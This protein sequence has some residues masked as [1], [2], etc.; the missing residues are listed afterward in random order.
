[1]ESSKLKNI[2]LLILLITN[3]LLLFLMVSQRLESR[4]LQDKTLTDAV[5]LLEEK[6][7][8]V[9]AEDLSHISFPEAMTAER[10]TA[11]EQRQFTALLGEGTTL[12]QKGLVAQYDGPWGQAEVRGDGAFSVLLNPNAYPAAEG[13]EAACAKNALKLIGFTA[14]G[15]ESDGATLT[16]YQTAA[17][18]TVYSCSVTAEFGGGSLLRLSGQR[19]VGDADQATGA[20]AKSVATLL[21]RFRRYLVESGDACTAILSATVGYTTVTD[22]TGQTE[23]VPILRLKTDTNLYD[24]NALTGSIQRV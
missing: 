8:S 18:C 23:L 6:G 12:T 15:F 20:A 21:V 13:E 1:M 11:E 22:R 16:A 3:L 19:L 5:Q 17:G 2:V 4:Q 14:S 7:I 24:L 10:D 9:K